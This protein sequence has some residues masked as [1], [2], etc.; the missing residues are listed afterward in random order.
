M[1]LSEKTDY[2][3][4]SFFLTSAL[5][6]DINLVM[7]V[8]LRLF[9]YTPDLYV[10]ARDELFQESS[11]SN[12][13]D[14]STMVCRGLPARLLSYRCYMDTMM[15]TLTAFCCWLE[16]SLFCR[17]SRFCQLWLWNP[18]EDTFLVA[19]RTSSKVSACKTAA[20]FFKACLISH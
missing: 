15:Y 18:M 16:S 1:E 14:R 2:F 6:L 12:R 10:S 3:R 4:T 17:L 5:K 13:S 8:W 7:F 20:F 11:H 19:F 9:Y